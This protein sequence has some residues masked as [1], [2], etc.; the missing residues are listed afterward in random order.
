MSEEKIFGSKQ[1][2]LSK[3][4]FSDL[5]PDPF[6]QFK[7]WYGEILKSEE[8]FPN[9]MVLS[10]A[11][12]EGYPSS[13]IVLLKGYNK[14]SFRFYTNSNSKKASEITDNPLCSLCF[15]W[16]LLER[17]VRIEGNVVILPDTKTDKYFETR[18][19]PSQIGAWISDQSM[20]LDSRETLENK[21]EE[22]EKA[23]AKKKIK[24]P[25]FWK[26]YGVVPTLFE[27]WQ[28]RDSRLHDRF[29]YHLTN[30][31]KWKIDRLYP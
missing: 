12:K 28:G 22:F 20:V 19:R 1:Y 5:N 26:G 14:K 23:H 2:K 21:F 18:P 30:N 15:W 8:K 31:S 17:Q 6:L 27:F 10:T 9:A 29:R 24:R 11:N 7:K 13:R 3:L 4:D 25:E 16:S